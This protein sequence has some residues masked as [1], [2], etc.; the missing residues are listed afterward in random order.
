MAKGLY[1]FL[2]L[3][4]LVDQSG[5]LTTDGALALEIFVAALGEETCHDEAQR[6]DTDHHQR[7]GHVLGQHEQQGAQNGQHAREQLGEAHEQAVGKGVH[8]GYHPADD[9]AGGVAVEVGEGQGLDLAHGLV[10][11]VA[12]D[13]ERDAVVADTE[14]PLRKGGG[15]GHHDDLHDD[16]QDGGK[17]HAALAQHK[18]D[19]I[20]AEDGDI[21]LGGHAYGGHYQAAHHKQAVGFDLMQDTAQ[22]GIALF[23]GQLTFCFCT[24]CRASPFLNWLA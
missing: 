5:L 18:V 20:A 2:A 12:A 16:V 6:G 22:R 3:D 19:G 21:Q 8:I 11:E 14:Q 17:V 15:H 13:G 4:H 1:H 10:A 23:R 7:D 9:V 24:H